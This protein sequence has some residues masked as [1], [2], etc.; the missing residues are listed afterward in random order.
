MRETLNSLL[1][2]IDA[3]FGKLHDIQFSAPWSPAPR[4]TC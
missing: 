3:T 4:S 2:A 1:K